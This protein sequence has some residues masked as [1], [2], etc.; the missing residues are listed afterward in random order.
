VPYG[1]FMSLTSNFLGVCHARV[2]AKFDGVRSRVRFD[3][4]YEVELTPMKNPVTGEEEPATLMKPKGFTSKQQE[5]CT[6]ATMRLSGQGLAY[7]HPGKYGEYSPFE[8][9]SG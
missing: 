7:E 9:K 4:V 3:G 2:E 6:T 1:I 8:Y 5:L